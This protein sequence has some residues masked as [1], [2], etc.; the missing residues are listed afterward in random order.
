MSNKITAYALVYKK[1]GKLAVLDT[2]LPIYWIKKVAQ[3]EVKK[4]T[5]CEVKKI[6]IEEKP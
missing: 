6:T 3:D 4:F 5:K 2:K 1:T